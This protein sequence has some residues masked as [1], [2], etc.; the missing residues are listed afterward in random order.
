CSDLFDIG[1]E[2]MQ[3]SAV[4]ER[5]LPAAYYQ[6]TFAAE[7]RKIAVVA[8]MGS[9]L[10]GQILEF[11]W[12]P[13]ERG[14][15]GGNHNPC[16]MQNL[17]IFELD[18]E[19][20]RSPLNANDLAPVEIGNSLLLEPKTVVDEA[21][22]GNGRRHMIPSS[23]CVSFKFQGTARTRD[24]RGIPGRAKKHSPRHGALPE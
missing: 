15:P 14:N 17:S 19:T 23:R 18:V 10:P 8:A 20:L 7:A 13:R 22:Q 9:Q 3:E 4:F 5:A 12:T 2:F 6:D 24:V 1:A 21:F 16:R 11:R